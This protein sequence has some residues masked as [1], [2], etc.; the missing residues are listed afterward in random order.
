M[1]QEITYTNA[2]TVNA[3]LNFQREFG[4]IIAQVLNAAPIE[5]SLGVKKCCGS[6]HPTTSRLLSPSEMKIINTDYKNHLDM[7]QQQ[8][9]GEVERLKVAALATL[10]KSNEN[11]LVCD[12][13]EVAVKIQRIVDAETVREVNQEIKSAF[14][15]IKVQH[16]KTFVSNL[17]RVVTESAVSVGFK[18]IAIQH[19]CQGLVRV[20][21]TNHTGQNLVAEIETAKNIDIHT[22]LIGF[23]DG[24]CQGVMRAF[25]DAMLARGLSVEHKEQMPTFG[26]PQMS[27]AK[28][29]VK[30]KKKTLRVFSD[31]KTTNIEHGNSLVNTLT[32][33]P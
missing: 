19:S 2:V 23:S 26:I 4:P 6:C 30:P 15:E 32:I 27:Y 28:M 29:L 14:K 3:P 8:K 16:T 1:S 18:K 31:D 21:G 20:V 9:C 22:E 5:I 33:K 10:A 7:M 13:K 25:D 17:A 11:L 12:P 24:S